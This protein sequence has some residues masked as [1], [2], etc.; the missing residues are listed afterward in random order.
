[1]GLWQR[2]NPR[3]GQTAFPELFTAI[4]KQ[5]SEPEGRKRSS[6]LSQPDQGEQAHPGLEKQAEKRRS[7]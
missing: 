3:K 6:T 4:S 7:N 2:N 5:V 1:M